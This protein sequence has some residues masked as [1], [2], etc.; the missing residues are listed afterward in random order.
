LKSIIAILVICIFSVPI[1]TS[2]NQFTVISLESDNPIS[3]AYVDKVVYK[4]VGNLDGSRVSALQSGLVDTL[5]QPIDPSNEATLNSNPDIEQHY[6]LRNGYGHITINCRDAPLNESVLRRAFAYAFN[7]TKVTSEI[8]D[9]W[10]QEHDSLV[11][12][13]S[14]W[15]IE[16]QLSPHYYTAEVAIGNDL[17]DNSTDFPII[18]EY[19]TYRGIPFNITI[20]YSST[21]GII[22]VGIA[23]I[24]VDALLALHIDAKTK[25]A[26]FNDFFLRLD[27]HGDYDM[28][29]Y[30]ADY[31]NDVDWLAYEYWSEYADMPWQNPTN[32]RSVAFD[33]WRHQLLSGSSYEEVY[34]A[35]AAMQ[36]ILHYNVPRLVVYE[37]KYLEA[38]KTDKF[39][40]YV[41]DL[42]WGVAGPWSN[43]KVHNINGSS[44]GGTFNVGIS[45][46][47]LS[48]NIFTIST[49][50]EAL[51]T[52]NLYSSLFKLGP[53]FKQYPDLAKN[54]LVERHA[55]NPSVPTG[56]TWLTFE[57]RNNTFWSDY[58]PL[59]A[60]D[61]A[62]T[63]VYL[64]ESYNYGNPYGTPFGDF[65]NALVISPLKVRIE[66]N[67]E[68]YWDMQ[69]YMNAKIIPKHVFNDE[70]GIGYNGWASWNPYFNSGYPHV[71]CG[72]FILSGYVHD[73]YCE[74][75]RNPL[76]YWPSGAKPK[77][78]SSTNL[79]YFQGTIGNQIH[80]V[81]E[82]DNP[83][84]Y[85]IF[86]NGVPIVAAPWNESDIYYNVDGLF[87]GT[88]NFTLELFD[89]SLNVA[90][91]TVWVTVLPSDFLNTLVI[92]A[93]IG[94]I[95]VVLIIGIKLY[96][97]RL[98][99]K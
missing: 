1:V 55:D 60:D 73:D 36:A 19:R 74:L 4:Y 79:T 10:S 66:F 61:V 99:G 17:L 46:M 34:A 42:G 75:S 5:F 56:Y 33:G 51:I 31:G 76:Y 62:F 22:G 13:P 29:F 38:C 86:Q 67:T 27:N 24:G 89:S 32:F 95:A 18:G 81:V 84:L 40:G 77:V 6:S 30:A 8:M 69:E 26:D 20:E 37:N 57:L 94:V 96:Q 52:S 71:T 9:G 83:L 23:Q 68:S 11:P 48:F 12:Y 88:Y 45:N 90:N 58:T 92:G 87:A 82:D 63:F 64:D 49:P 53:D 59:T 65:E 2:S 97:K 47:P 14:G 21:S 44:F 3:G 16:D 70:T 7:K 85:F 35:A 39:T 91:N 93:S 15:C 98:Q 78:L 41:D 28:I 72:P 50:E 54:V 43:V 25:A 80:W